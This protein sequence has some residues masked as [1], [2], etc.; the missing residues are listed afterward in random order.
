MARQTDKLR[1]PIAVAFATSD[2]SNA[3]TKVKVFK[4]KEIDDLI[5]VN[6]V[7]PGIPAKA[8][9]KEVV[10]GKEL[11]KKLVKKYDNN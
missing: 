4:N 9:I 10:V 3:R 11:V 7:V 1:L 8:V 6:F 5:N 2:R